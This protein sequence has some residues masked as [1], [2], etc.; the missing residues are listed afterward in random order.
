MKTTLFFGCLA[1]LSMSSCSNPV[2]E[3]YVIEGTA[4]TA[5]E[6]KMIF[7]NEISGKD[8]IPKDTAFV[9]N[10]KFGFTGSQDTVKNY[11]ITF[12]KNDEFRAPVYMVL[13]NDTYNVSLDSVITVKGSAL[14]DSLRS[15]LD[16]NLNLRKNLISANREMQR[17]READSLTFEQEAELKAK[18]EQINQ[19]TYQNNLDF[20]KANSDN[21]AGALVFSW[22]YYNFD[23]KEQEEIIAGANEVFKN[24]PSVMAILNRLNVLKRTS[25]GQQF[26]DITM[27][28]PEATPLALSDVVL[29]NKLTLVDFW[30][31][32]CAPCRAEMPNI[33]AIYKQYKDKGLE[34]VGISFDKDE[35]R[36]KE[37]IK[38]NNLN[39]KH[40]S[41]LK[42][43]QSEAGKAY[44]I[45][46]IPHV[47]L[48]DQQGKIVS[49]GLHGEELKKK[50]DE[51]LK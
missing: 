20:I 38:E 48:I 18:V 36:W 37:Y 14:N 21:V 15:L 26:V 42:Q 46:S 7:L 4:G 5:L 19:E 10:G 39:W 17:L 29:N 49:R 23:D 35:S 44:A 12:E 50:V 27:L 34:V 28:T 13:E 32:W 31:T 30:A 6:G 3:K 33:V 8:L 11:A 9:E 25:E 1:V 47:I 40:M 24:Y 45:N 22:N 43:W 2:S 51:L 41:D 16:K